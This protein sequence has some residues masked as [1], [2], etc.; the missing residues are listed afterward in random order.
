M[1]IAYMNKIPVSVPYSFPMGADNLA[2]EENG[3]LYRYF[4]CPDSDEDEEARKIA[5]RPDNFFVRD[6]MVLA[7][8]ILAYLS[9]KKIALS[10]AVKDIPRFYTTQRYVS[11]GENPGRL[12]KEFTLAKSGGPEGVVYQSG[13]SRAVVRPLKSGSGIMIFAESFKSETAGSLCDE[14]QRKIKQAE[15]QIRK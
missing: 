1:K 6:G 7:V 2:E 11:V 14:I 9:D 3:R 15:E 5:K 4:N 12:I 8:M 10:E 13:D